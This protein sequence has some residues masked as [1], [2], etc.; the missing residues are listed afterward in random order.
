MR[1]IMDRLWKYEEYVRLLSHDNT[2][3]L[4]MAKWKT[5]NSKID[6]CDTLAACLR[7][8]G[9]PRGIAVLQDIY[10]NE[11]NADYIGRPLECLSLLH[12]ADIPELPAIRER[13][14]EGK[15]Q[16]GSRIKEINDAF[17]DMENAKTMGKVIPFQRKTKKKG[18]NDPCPC[19]SGKKYKKCCLNK[20]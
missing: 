4:I 3:D 8:I 18:R 16:Q 6:S 20:S 13:R 2:L 15:K 19:G 1:E 17:K 10:N 7:G 5:E 9:D 12:N 14:R 11:N